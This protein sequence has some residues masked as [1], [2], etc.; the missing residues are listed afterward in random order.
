LYKYK[1]MNKIKLLHIFHL[2][3]LRRYHDDSK[4][5]QTCNI[6]IFLSCWRFA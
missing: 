2:A 6:Q 5:T 3:P 1:Y 4:G